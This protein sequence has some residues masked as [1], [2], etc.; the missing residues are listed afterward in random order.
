MSKTS[1][2]KHEEASKLESVVGKLGYAIGRPLISAM[3]A[4]HETLKGENPIKTFKET[5]KKLS[6][7]NLNKYEKEEGRTK[8]LARETES[9]ATYSRY[10]SEKNKR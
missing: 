1:T 4:S 9:N 8:R 6:P 10:Q 3:H 5:Y 7:E 2:E